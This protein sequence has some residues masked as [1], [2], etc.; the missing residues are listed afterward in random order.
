MRLTAS[1]IIPLRDR[2][3]KALGWPCGAFVV[4]TVRGR[5]L[6]VAAPSASYEPVMHSGV[7]CRLR[8]F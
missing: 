4:E 8:Q 3:L 5:L 2:G 7:A 1:V 6:Q